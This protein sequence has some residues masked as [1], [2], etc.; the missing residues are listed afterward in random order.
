MRHDHTRLVLPV[1]AW[2]YLETNDRQ[3]AET[4]IEPAVERATTTGVYLYLVDALRIRGMIERHRRHRR[5]ARR[6]FEDALQLTRTL[7]YERGQGWI[8]YENGVNE[9]EMGNQDGARQQWEEA[10]TIF[11]RLGVRPLIEQTEQA[12]TLMQ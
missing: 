4:L 3:R 5:E 6:T 9:R 12:L 8:L 2:A 1:L 11:R 7:G 10:L